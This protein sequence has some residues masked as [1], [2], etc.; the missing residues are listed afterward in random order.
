[1]KKADGEDERWETASLEWIHRIR[2]ERQAA[3]AGRP[4]VP[5]AGSKAES[6]A[7]QYGLKLGRRG[8]PSRG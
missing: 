7:Q 8:T 2:R 3:R 6:L 5:L 4:I 1:M